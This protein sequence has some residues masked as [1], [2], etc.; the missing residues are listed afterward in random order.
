LTRTIAEEDFNVVFSGS[1]RF[2]PQSPFRLDAFVVVM[3]WCVGYGAVAVSEER[4]LLSTTGAFSGGGME[5]SLDERK[6]APPGD[7]FLNA[8]I[9][10]T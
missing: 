10:P 2:K 3:I 6:S 7:T 1:G 8:G 5:N 9:L 4:P